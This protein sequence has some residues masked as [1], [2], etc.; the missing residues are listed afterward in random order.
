ARRSP[1]SPAPRRSRWPRAGGNSRAGGGGAASARP[2]GV[3]VGLLDVPR[4][5]PDEVVA[6]QVRVERPVRKE[7]PHRLGERQ[8]PAGRPRGFAAL[9][10]RA[11]HIELEA[12]RP[13]FLRAARRMAG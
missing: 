4:A 11:A 7:L 6:L 13:R 2:F 5:E 3:A 1:S 9:L 10:R 8:A 12:Q